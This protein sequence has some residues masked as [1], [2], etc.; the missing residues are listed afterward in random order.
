MKSVILAFLISVGTAMDFKV[1]EDN[2]KFQMDKRAHL[3]VSFGLY[4][5]SYTLFNCS[6]GVAML[7]A[8]GVGLGYEIYQ[9]FNHKVHWGFSKEDMVYN[10]VGVVAANIIHRVFIWGEEFVNF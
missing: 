5:T 8:S 10:I 9:G 4:Y 2:M 6:D 7:L 3:G 1:V